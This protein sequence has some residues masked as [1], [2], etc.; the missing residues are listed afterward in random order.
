MND[1]TVYPLLIRFVDHPEIS[2]VCEDVATLPEGVPF[3]VEALR[4]GTE[5]EQATL[6]ARVL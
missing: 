5:R 6:P 4:F 1:L 3:R 2:V